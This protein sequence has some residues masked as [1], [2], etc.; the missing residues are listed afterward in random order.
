M[1]QKIPDNHLVQGPVDPAWASQ[2]S[3]AL[4]EGQGAAA[5]FLGIIRRDAGDQEG[6]AVDAIDY[7][8]YGPMAEEIFR[9]IEEQVL[10]QHDIGLCWIRHSVGMVKAG[11]ASM[12]VFVASAH[13]AAA[14]D[15]LRAAVEAVKAE[16]PVWKRELFNDGSHRWVDAL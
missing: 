14:F 9:N 11:E 5:S 13:R 7:S 10:E 2:A 3:A 16:A 12:L 15:A 1:S 6:T 8:A 4:P